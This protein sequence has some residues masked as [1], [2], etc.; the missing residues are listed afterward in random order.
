MGWDNLDN[1]GNHRKGTSGSAPETA[2]FPMMERFRPGRAD[3][4]PD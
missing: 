3:S 4:F 2:G 1:R